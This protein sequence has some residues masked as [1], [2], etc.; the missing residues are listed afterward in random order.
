MEHN[1]AI[2]VDI[3][4]S[5]ISSMAVGLSSGTLYRETLSGNY[6]DNQEQAFRIVSSWASCIRETM[7]KI[8]AGSTLKGIGFAM[9]G[10][11]DYVRGIALFRGVPK[12]ENLYGFNIADAMRS[13]LD[14]N[15]DFRL[16]FINDATSFALGEAWAGGASGAKRMAAITLGTGFGS[17]FIADRVPVADGPLVPGLG[18]LYHLPFREGIADDYFS[19]RWFRIR[20]LEL[21]GKDVEGVRELLAESGSDPVVSSLFTE[22]G[23]NLGIFLAPWLKRFDAEVLVTGGNISRAWNLFGGDLTQTLAGEGCNTRVVVSAFGEDAALLG[24]A[25]LFNEELWPDI[26]KTL[27]LM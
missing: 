4:G 1:L 27:H 25:F 16:R 26:E 11:F 23:R 15:D 3:G 22:F 10:P 19:T 8:P 7:G 6:V 12:F 21:T 14:L 9:P 5:H 2:G 17:A 18:C 24:S 20:Y 13:S